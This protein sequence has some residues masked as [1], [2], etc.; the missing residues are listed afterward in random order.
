MMKLRNG[1][2]YDPIAYK[3]LPM[4]PVMMHVTSEN[5]KSEPLFNI[6]PHC[7]PIKDISPDDGTDELSN[8]VDS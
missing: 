2:Q 7:M 5:L 6:L 4:N 1:L 8:G 3:T